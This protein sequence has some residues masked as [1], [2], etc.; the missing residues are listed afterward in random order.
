MQV[1]KMASHDQESFHLLQI[2]DSASDSLPDLDLV[3]L[4]SQQQQK[5]KK[6]RLKRRERKS[7]NSRPHGHISSGQKSGEDT[8]DG[9][10]LLGLLSPGICCLNT[11]NCV[12]MV[13]SVSA[14]LVLVI[15][16]YITTSLNSRIVSLE[17]QLRMKIADDDSKGVSEKLQLLE[18]RIDGL[19][20][21]QTGVWDSLAK[22]NKA[23][24]N[25]EKRVASLNS[26]ESSEMKQIKMDLDL[27]SKISK[28]NEESIKDVANIVD[29][30]NISS[31]TPTKIKGLDSSQWKPM[32]SDGRP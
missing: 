7:A 31:S 12:M 14:V 28:T 21:N 32:E 15:M 20:T 1:G 8:D 17:Q 3:S 9:G 4:N 25:V 27:L 13:V 23:V 18:S 29:N 16:T 19:V 24:A 2:S 5:K 22:I 11:N 6:V 26:S 10:G 30:F